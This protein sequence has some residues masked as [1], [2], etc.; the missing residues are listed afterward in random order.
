M[1]RHAIRLCGREI[2]RPGHICAFFDS[3]D[4]EYAT[5]LPFLKDG[6]ESGEQI[7]NVLDAVRMPEH[8]ARLQAAGISPDDQDVALATSEETYLA[9]GSFDMDRMVKFVRD[10]LETAYA[11]GKR[12]RTAG[13]MDWIHREGVN[14][15]RA[16]EYEARMNL[17]VPDFDCTFT[18]IYDLAK[19]DGSMIVDIMATH[20]YVILRGRIRE[21][22][23]YV[24]PEI[25]L[26]DL[27]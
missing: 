1:Q 8:R 7:V 16:L 9:G 21:N 15:T 17:L 5:L 25:Y 19:L 6:L 11:K 24:P 20:P 23:F 10:H 3:R 22:S 27:A 18:C 26:R 2:D 12:I 4:E 13:W 14:A